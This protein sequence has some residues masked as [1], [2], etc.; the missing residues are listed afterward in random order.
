VQYYEGAI[1]VSGTMDGKET[2]GSG[3]I[4]MTGYEE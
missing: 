1:S 2:G 3:F 4:E